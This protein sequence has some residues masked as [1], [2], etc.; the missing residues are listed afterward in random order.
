METS[1]KLNSEIRIKPI[2]LVIKRL[3]DIIGSVIGIIISFPIMLIIS[4]LI[5]IDS[6]GPIIFIQERVG[7]N[8]KIFCIY[9]FRSMVN[10]AED[11]LEEIINIYEL[12]EPVYKIKDDPRVT[13]VG[14]VLR[15]T[16]L[17]ELP[18]FFNV[19]QGEM[20]LVGP[21]PEA[22]WLVERY[23]DE[24]K[25]RFMM[26]PGITGP[27]QINGTP[28]LPLNSRI[29]LERAYMK[30]YSLL[31]DFEIMIKTIPA[32]ISKDGCY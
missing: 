23:T 8:G 28:E 17:D 10:N 20:S 24:Q 5:K 11:M 19:L 29:D 14:K 15:R 3:I 1:S 25:V 12:E 2:V 16:T 18:Q 21:R 9:K 4:V 26:K 27:V 6:E 22:A 30:N 32:I 31:K 13:R 7:K